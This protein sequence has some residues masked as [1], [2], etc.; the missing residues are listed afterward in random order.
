MVA[1]VVEA[2]VHRGYLPF[3]LVAAVEVAV[4]LSMVLEVVG[5]EAAA[6]DLRTLNRSR[7]LRQEGAAE[8]VEEES[9]DL[10]V[11]Q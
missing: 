5:E 2:A 11:V 6:L 8:V 9:E 4:H 10:R 3:Q 1:A 7:T